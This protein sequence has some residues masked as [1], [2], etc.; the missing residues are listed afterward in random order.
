ME[1]DVM[2]LHLQTQSTVINQFDINTYSCFHR[3]AIVSIWDVG[4]SLDHRV[5]TV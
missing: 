2:M 3:Q 1:P 5:L 4:K